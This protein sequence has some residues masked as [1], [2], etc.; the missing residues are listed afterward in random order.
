MSG[1][2]QNSEAANFVA[3]K[4]GEPEVAV[5]ARRDPT[6]LAAGRGHGE[7]GEGSRRGDAAD[8]VGVDLGE[9]EVAV[10]ARRDA[11]RTAIGRG[12]EE[13]GDGPR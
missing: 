2:T 13:L 3:A 12:H 9:P 10:R 7:L 4:L 6:R 1:Q 5:R 8:L 11:N